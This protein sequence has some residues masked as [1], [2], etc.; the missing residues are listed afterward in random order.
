M[1][2]EGSPAPPEAVPAGFGVT[3][4]LWSLP[5]GPPEH[6]SALEQLSG[7][8]V[9]GAALKIYTVF[10]ESLFESPAFWGSSISVC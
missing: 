4:P 3:L 7:L 6:P 5:P 8:P 1:L 10:Q 2:A 9:S